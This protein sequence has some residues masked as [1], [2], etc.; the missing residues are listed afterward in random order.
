MASAAVAVPEVTLR[1]S[2]ARPVPAVG[3]GAVEFPPVEVGFRHFDTA[4][5]YGTEALLGEALAEATRRWLVASQEEAFDRHVQAV[6]HLGATR[7]SCSRRSVKAYG[8]YA[9]ATSTEY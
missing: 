9:T 8:K 4:T 3:M 1:S 5:L 7:T 2:N 6:V